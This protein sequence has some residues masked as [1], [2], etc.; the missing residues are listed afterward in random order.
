M[1]GEANS[2][3]RSITSISVGSFWGSNF[4][5]TWAA[6]AGLFLSHRSG[7]VRGFIE[8][9]FGR[10]AIERAIDLSAE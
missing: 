3:T 2:P 10:K 7:G 9:L 5:R 8:F 4:K 1:I 6:D